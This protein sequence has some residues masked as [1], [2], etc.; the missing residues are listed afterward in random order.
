VWARQSAEFVSNVFYTNAQRP[1]SPL[2]AFY[3]L[4]VLR[5]RLNGVRDDTAETRHWLAGDLC[6]LLEGCGVPEE[7]VM[8]ALR[9]LYERRLQGI[10]HAR[11]VVAPAFWASRMIGRMFAAC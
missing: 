3:I 5:Q 6:N 10:G 7:L 2:L 9:R 1:E 8:Q 11:K 4:W